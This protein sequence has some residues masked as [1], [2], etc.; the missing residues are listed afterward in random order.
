MNVAKLMEKLWTM[1][2]DAEVG[3]VWDGEVRSNVEHIWLAR[4]GNVVLAD[5]DHYVYSGDSRPIDA[6]TTEQNRYW[7]TSPEGEE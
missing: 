7:K 2:R 1:P 3:Y 5:C 6:P 4:N